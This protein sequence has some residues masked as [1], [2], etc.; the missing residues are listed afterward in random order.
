MNSMQPLVFV[1]VG[2]CGGKTIKTLLINNTIKHTSI[3]INKCKFNP[4]NRYLIVLRN[5]IP[6]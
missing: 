6:Y 5:P 4:N 3:H 2:K 1:H